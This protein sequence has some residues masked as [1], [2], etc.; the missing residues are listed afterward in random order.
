MRPFNS[1]S[2]ALLA[3]LVVP[4]VSAVPAPKAEASLEGNEPGFDSGTVSYGTGSAS[5]SAA[6]T[7]TKSSS[8]ASSSGVAVAS[9]ATTE[10]AVSVPTQNS[11][12][13]AMLNFNTNERA[14][15]DKL[16]YA[17]EEDGLDSTSALTFAN[18]IEYQKIALANMSS[19]FDDLRNRQFLTLAVL[20]GGLCGFLLCGLLYALIAC[21]RCCRTRRRARKQRKLEERNSFTM[22]SPSQRKSEKEAA[23]IRRGGKGN[24]DRW[25]IDSTPTPAAK[26]ERFVSVTGEEEHDISP[27]SSSAFSPSPTMHKSYSNTTIATGTPNGP[28][29]RY[30]TFP[31]TPSSSQGGPPRLTINSIPASRGGQGNEKTPRSNRPSTAG[32][33][34]ISDILAE[35]DFDVDEDAKETPSDKSSPPTTGLGIA[36]P[37]SST[38]PTFPHPPRPQTPILGASISRIYSQPNFSHS[39]PHIPSSATTTTAA[40]A[41]TMN[42]STSSWTVA[43]ARTH[44]SRTSDEGSLV[45]IVS[46]NGNPAATGKMYRGSNSGFGI[47]NGGSGR[48]RERRDGRF[49]PR[50]E[51]RGERI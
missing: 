28:A 3:L 44:R 36:L 6:A 12:V 50:R 8:S 27:S 11:W 41:K 4:L 46:G 43:T 9:S 18:V 16:T 7:G 14:D 48:D 20:I 33:T 19:R 29:P 25:P 37:T 24:N 45:G 38:T 39:V 5:T 51:G 13:S 23:N 42:P 40:A 31:P 30:T 21:I 10:I 35:F 2:L 1:R 17:F 49:Y 22:V 34:S 32:R 15:F 26:A 47:A